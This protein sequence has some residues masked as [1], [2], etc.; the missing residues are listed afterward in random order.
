MD[1]TKQNPP[2]WA[3]LL[4]KAVEEPGRILE[5]Y[6]AF[7][8]YSLGNCLAAAWQL[9]KREIPLS[10]INTFNGWKNLGRYVKKGEKAIVLCVPLTYKAKKETGAESD[11]ERF[12]K[13]FVWKPAFFALSQT[14]GAD[15]QP[16]PVTGTWNKATALAALDITEVPFDLLDGNC[17]GFAKGRSVSVS[18]L[19]QLPHKT[20][21][22]ECS[23]IVL[24]HTLQGD[25]SDSVE[26][27]KALKEVEAEATAM[28]LCETL[29]LSGADYCRGYIQSWWKSDTIPEQSAQKIFSAAHKILTAGQIGGKSEL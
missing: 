5:A 6:T 26:L 17:Q 19:A 11:T 28:L 1:T 29:Q 18:P 2:Q 10:P 7:H 20:L 21:F 15:F 22:H 4:K 25:C 12:I 14:D 9:D 13:G 27:P 3:D 23:H 24:G 16:E 8:H